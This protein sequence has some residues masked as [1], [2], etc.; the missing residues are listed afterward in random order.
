[1]NKE[2]LYSTRLMYS[3]SLAKNLYRWVKAILVIALIFMFLP[4]QQSIRV[5]GTLTAFMP[6]DRPQ[7]IHSTIPG[8]IEHWKV[9]EGQFV[10][11]NDTIVVLSEIKDNFFDPKI[12][13]RMSNQIEARKSSLEATGEKITA[14]E[15]QITALKSG[16][17]FSL[18][19]ARNRLE[20]ARLQVISDSMDYQAMIIQNNIAAQ[21]FERFKKLYEKDLK[22]KTEFEQR[23]NQFQR[24]Q[25]QLI[26]LENKLLSSKNDYINAVI[27]LNSIEASFQDKIA[28]AESDKSSTLA[29]Y[30]NTEMDINRMETQY[31]N[32]RIRSG[33]YV[34]RAPQDGYVVRATREGIGE[35]IKEGEPIV[36]VLPSNASLATELFVMPMDM[37]LVSKNRTVRLEFDGWPALQFSGWPDASVGTFS[38][39]IR[40]VDN[41]IHENKGRFR[42]LVTESDGEAREPWPDELRIGG[43]VKAWVMLETVPI[44]YEIWRQLNGFPPRYDEFDGYY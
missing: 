5:D 16:M 1:M 2:K 12:L 33:F 10:S 22:S 28:K 34:I 32:L 19:Q 20:Q 7:T 15:N 13:P 44:W 24:T 31:D 3:P 41:V 8:R 23:E 38:G 37:P 36:K 27:N 18:D 40:V 35:T 11:R 14:L 43:G 25:A 6:E 17:K 29:S 26:S 4:W 42:I 9:S 21:Q 30:F 39:R